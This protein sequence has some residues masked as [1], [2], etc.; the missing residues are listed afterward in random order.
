MMRERGLGIDHSTVFRWVQRYAPEINKRVRQRL[1]MS[2][3]S[4]RVDE[5]YIK[6]GKTC[7]YLYRAVDKEGQTIEFIL[8]AKRDVSAAKRFFKKL[9]RAGHRRLPF[10]ISVDKNAA[11]PGAFTSSQDEK[12]IPHDCK[13]R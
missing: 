9:M 1:K 12:V 7:K 4:Y 2:G 3:T 11:Y 8:S 10:S 6:F 13:L 5:T